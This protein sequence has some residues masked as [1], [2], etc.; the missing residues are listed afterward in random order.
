[1]IFCFA[2][3]SHQELQLGYGEIHIRGQ[4]KLTISHIIS[5]FTH[6][7][8]VKECIYKYPYLNFFDSNL[9]GSYNETF[10]VKHS[11]LMISKN[12]LQRPSVSPGKKK[13]N[14]LQRNTCASPR[15]FVFYYNLCFGFLRPNLP[16]PCSEEFSFI[17]LEFLGTCVF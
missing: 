16:Q 4:G 17:G 8:K 5:I 15:L 7:L 1:M 12:V 10:I 3:V 2:S 11:V 14:V 6:K 9:P 13:K